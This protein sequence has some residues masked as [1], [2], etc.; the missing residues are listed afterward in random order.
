MKIVRPRSQWHFKLSPSSNGP[1]MIRS[2]HC[3]DYGLFID[4]YRSIVLT[5]GVSFWMFVI[6][7]K[8]DELAAASSSYL[9]QD[10]W[11]S[12][13]VAEP[14]GKVIECKLQ[15]FFDCCQHF[16]RSMGKSKS[17]K[18]RQYLR[19][20]HSSSSWTHVK[21]TGEKENEC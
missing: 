15:D 4:P 14:N 19:P 5:D 17:T 9:S 6:L 20:I 3:Q 2:M 16:P 8:A 13:S 10:Q 11:A 21:W 12:T 1:E 7:Q 18:R